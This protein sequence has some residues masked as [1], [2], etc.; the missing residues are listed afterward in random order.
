MSFAGAPSQQDGPASKQGNTAELSE[1]IHKVIPRKVS[2]KVSTMLG[3]SSELLDLLLPPA[4][5][6]CNEPIAGGQDF[7]RLCEHAL[8][9]SE[10]AM[11]SACRRC[12]RPGAISTN[13]H[14][15]RT[16]PLTEVEATAKP[17]KSPDECVH[18]KSE[19][20]EFDEVIAR[21][22]YQGRVC[23]AIVAA[24]YAHQAALGAS[25]GNRL[26]ERACEALKG[27]IPDKITFVPSHV[28]RQFSRGGNG[29]IAIAQ[30]V[31]RQISQ[32]L[33]R[34]VLGAESLLRTTRKI[35]KQAW[36]SDDERRKNVCGA[37]SVKKSYAL[38]RSPRISPRIL[39]SPRISPRIFDQHI[40]LVDDVLTTGATANEVAKVLREA[41]ARRVT[42]AVVARAVWST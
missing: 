22:T 16:T 19:R 18:C 30:A 39:R 10:S 32:H 38:L 29:N 27:D 28:A 14:L 15:S 42:L 35:K 4:C 37:F 12:G 36:L 2:R 24:K 20:F 41:G 23:D 26:G 21:W 33:D 8:T 31:A 6:L 13:L 11:S 7:C 25:L 34:R 1:T 9:L 17:K 5:R 40:L 3:S